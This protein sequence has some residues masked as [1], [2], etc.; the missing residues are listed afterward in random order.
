VK[1]C[2][3]RTWTSRAV[4]TA[5]LLVTA[6]CATLPAKEADAFHELSTAQR[7]AFVGLTE[8]ER[9]ALIAFASSARNASGSSWTAQH[10]GDDPTETA[11]CVLTFRDS[12]GGKFALTTAARNARA[13]IGGLAKYGDKMAQLAEA[14]DLATAR[15]KTQAVGAAVKGLATAVDFAVP[16]VGAVVDLAIFAES[17]RLKEKRRRALLQAARV[18][19]PIVEVAADRLGQ[20]AKPLRANVITVS[21]QRVRDALTRVAGLRE[22]QA[23]LTRQRDGLKSGRVTSAWRSW[24]EIMA[25]RPRASSKPPR[26]SM[27][28]DRSRP[29]LPA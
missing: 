8:T 23:V 28:P 6:S 10:C 19:Q 20:I 27:P 7:D 25:S 26:T 17:A 2:K 16:I 3:L 22:Q 21:S 11:D 18:A 4:G 29:T 13:V 1:I 14:K 12:G 24:K 5:L 15:E 9:K